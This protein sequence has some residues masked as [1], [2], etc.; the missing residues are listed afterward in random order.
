MVRKTMKFLLACML[1]CTGVM[2]NVQITKAAQELI[3]YEIYPKPQDISYG[4][5]QITLS[6]TVNVVYDNEI[7]AETRARMKEVT[8]ILGLKLKENSE[9]QEGLTNIFV[10]VKGT[11]DKA[12]SYI[13]SKY[14]QDEE[15]YNKIDAYYLNVNENNEIAVLGKDTDSAFY[16]L[17][18]LYHVFQQVE[19]KQLRTFTVEDY[20]DVASRGFIEGYYGNPWSTE[21]RVN[22]MTWSGYYKL[23]SY[24]YA[25]KDDP[26]HNAKWRELYTDDEINTK[27]KPLADAGNKSKTRFVYALHPYM[28][29]SIRYDS[30]EHYQEDLKVMQ[31]KFEQVIEAGV[32][33]IAILADDAGNVGADNYIKT[34]EDMTAWLKEMQKVYP[35]LKLT[36]PFCTQEY[37]YNGQAYYSRFPEN[38]QIVMTGGK[39][40]GEVSQNF[41][42][43]FTNIAGRGPYMWINWPC[44]D[45]SKKHLIMGGYDNFLHPN[46]NPENIQGIVLNP[47][48]QSEPSKVAIFGNASY[49]WNI[50]SSKEEA[51]QIWNDAFKYVDH[52]G[53]YETDAS[54][55]LR[56]LSKHMI[57]QAMDNRVVALDESIELRDRLTEIKDLLSADAKI[58]IAKIDDLIH[59]FEVLQ[60]AAKVYREQAGDTKIR[61]QI[62]YWLNCWDDTTEAA[63][64]Y[65]T[66]IKELNTSN[67]NSVILDNFSKGQAAFTK[68][69]TYGFNYV[70]HLE[71]AEVGVQHIV[72]FIKAMESYISIKVSTLV[73]PDKQIITPITN[74]T[75]TPTSPMQNMLDDSNTTYAQWKSPNSAKAGDYIGITYTQ[76]INVNEV[77]F[78]MSD[79]ATNNKN[80]FAKAKLQY[81]EDGKEWKDIEGTEKDG[82]A[83]EF[84]ANDLDLQIKG[85]RII[86]TQDTPDV[87]L[88]IRGI[89]IN[90]EE[91]NKVEGY[92]PKLIRTSE[93]SVYN[94]YGEDRLVD[95]DDDSYVWYRTR[96]ED[97]SNKDDY[98]GFDLR[99]VYTI[100][101]VRFI[102]GY[103]GD[104]WKNYALEYSVDGINYTEFKSYKQSENKKIVEEDFNG[105]EARYVRIRNKEDQNTWLKMADFKV[106]VID[107][108]D[109]VFTN[110]EELAGLTM[111]LSDDRAA[112]ENYENITLQPGQYIGIKLPRIR[113][114]E[115]ITSSLVNAENITLEVS[116]ND[117]EWNVYSTNSE[118]V[119]ARYIRLMNHSD[120]AITFS[121]DKLEVLSNEIFAP[122]L[123]ETTFGI[124]PGWGENEDSRDNGAA[125][126]GNVDTTTEFGTLPE[127]GQYA[128]YDL[129]QERNISKLEILCQ[130]SAL[131]Y[132]RDGE[133]SISDDLETWTKVI[134]IGDGIEN[135]DDANVKCIDSDA[136]YTANS[137]Y[138]NKVSKT[139]TLEQPQKA[140]Y[141][142]IE[143]TASNKN[144]AI[145]FNEIFINDGEYVPTEN[146]PSFASN[147]IEARGFAPSN[148][149]DGDLTTSYKP[150]DAKA[151]YISYKLSENLG[152]K[153]LNIVQS[154]TPSHA[155]VMGLV[156]DGDKKE[157]VQLG[158]LDTAFTEIYLPF[159]DNLFEVKFEWEE[160]Q[161]PQISEIILLTDKK[162]GTDHTALDEFIKSLD[163]KEENYTNASYLVFKKAFENAQSVNLNNNSTQIELDTAL[164]E[165]KAA[166]YQLVKAGNLTLIEDELNSIA[167]L[168]EEEYT[169]QSYTVL[170]N[171]VKEAEKLLEKADVSEAEV[172]AMLEKLQAAKASLVT[173]TEMS[174]DILNQYIKD[175][176]LDEVDLNLY[177]SST[178][179]TFDKALSAAHAILNNDDAT[180]EQVENAY[181]QLQK[182]RADLVLKATKEQIQSLKDWMASY[183][184]TAYTQKSWKLFVSVC[185]AVMEELKN[186]LTQT[187]IIELRNEI[188][189]A[190]KNLVK[191]ADKTNV[192][193]LLDYVYGLDKNDYTL[194]SY[195]KLIASANKIA[196]Q[197]K[198]KDLT[199]EEADMLKAQLEKAISEL[200]T[201]KKDENKNTVENET[202]DKN[203]VSTGVQNNVMPFALLS[204]LVFAGLV[205]LN[206][207][208]KEN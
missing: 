198:N 5:Q 204:I 118:N 15:L 16:G 64:A 94:G 162:Y 193:G 21:D 192:E 97:M 185:D 139:G 122:F 90:N 184:E 132:L 179:K 161:A 135:K 136:G 112:I 142:K 81:T 25:P 75:D 177:M 10:G 152:V 51:D 120:H 73:D 99:E 61:D 17:T 126:D 107:E 77:K 76:P 175:N 154:G 164:E 98:V 49:S 111:N 201:A 29:N 165:L 105:I 149:F 84:F 186:E 158:A 6:D 182:A 100:D 72:P 87:W 7:D 33:Q 40:W 196:E 169:E 166:F 155:K 163:V 173:K 117:V 70:D 52:N 188:E 95:D 59:E 36:I 123:K 2:G 9:A 35:D 3:N 56:E 58:D 11:K 153:K 176:K 137:T 8:D 108:G 88:S 143:A 63:L 80:T 133:I 170:M 172:T 20:A 39:V 151:G 13:E 47:M 28:N 116:D 121:I 103:N 113:D 197:L 195:N 129:G 102:M 78:L 147:T 69:K 106:N 93:Y 92:N 134:T 206:K 54:N 43:T 30:E 44:T 141:L 18:T 115:T 91:I 55:A 145:V 19:N 1:V 159:W 131:N 12:S 4:N 27:I 128:I 150:T 181:T 156:G 57:N 207:K 174:K 180:L 144:R 23:N 110:S 167:K 22:L 65:L 37:M 208:R 24:F 104:F 200:E 146:N 34:L 138:P 53:P 86:C 26:K 127:K 74:R 160:N 119:T 191:A 60:N 190:A 50:W 14:P 96:T 31:N 187:R 202:G 85:I 42:D 32:R 83:L 38:V 157:W 125:F 66:A 109:K 101:N 68:S 48:Q 205:V 168:H 46:V 89:Y 41:T 45:N 140:R 171:V 199:Q 203:S 67:N 148:M 183:D 114:I 79:S 82:K 178:A 62:V 124:V 194:E 189:A 71:Y 130:D